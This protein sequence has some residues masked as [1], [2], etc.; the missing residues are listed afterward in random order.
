MDASKVPRRR[1]RGANE[2][3][4]RLKSPLL[5]RKDGQR[6]RTVLMEKRRSWKRLQDDFDEAPEPVTSTREEEWE[7][8]GH[9]EETRGMLM[10]YLDW[11]RS[12]ISWVFR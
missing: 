11:A 4:S 1:K 6:L 10:Q 7:A 9:V 5:V 8:V 2:L 3:T 12:W